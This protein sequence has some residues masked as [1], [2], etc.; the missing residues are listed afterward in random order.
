MLCGLLGSPK[1]TCNGTG[2]LRLQR[3]PYSSRVCEASKHVAAHQPQLGRWAWTRGLTVTPDSSQA[4]KAAPEERRMKWAT[5][6]SLMCCSVIWS[7][8]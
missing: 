5:R 3:T 6:T 1:W 8:R 7:S 4:E 2:A